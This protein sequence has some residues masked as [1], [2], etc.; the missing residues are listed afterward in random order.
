MKKEKKKG[1]CLKSIGVVVLVFFI[2]GFAFSLFSDD[3]EQDVAQNGLSSTT[4]STT[5]ESSGISGVEVAKDEPYGAIDEFDYEIS[6]NKVKLSNF[7]GKNKILEIK[8]KYTIDGK[9]YKTDLS[10]F[11]VGN[12][13]AETLILDDGIKKV[14][15]SIFNSCDV[16]AVFFPKSMKKVYDYTLSYM[17][18]DDGEMIQIYYGGTQDEWSQ[19][20]TEYQRAKLEDADSAED[21]GVSIADKINEMI[22]SEYDSS[23]FEFFFSASPDDLM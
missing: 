7:N 13:P 22:G 1:G 9:E 2:I 4:Q 14:S 20:F 5:E 19:I 23:Q 16:K 11:Q 8:S 15:T 3:E 21:V 18:P 17:H 10:E 12:C 6:G